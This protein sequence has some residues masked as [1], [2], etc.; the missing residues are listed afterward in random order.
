MNGRTAKRLRKALFDEMVASGT[1][2][3]S[4]YE[5]ATTRRGNGEQAQMLVCTGFRKIYR[6]M[7]RDLKIARRGQVLGTP[8]RNEAVRARKRKARAH[9]RVEYKRRAAE[10]LAAR[11]AQA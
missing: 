5:I 10:I 6:E 7:K 2:V 8:D 4:S 9:A 3:H 11:E 1:I